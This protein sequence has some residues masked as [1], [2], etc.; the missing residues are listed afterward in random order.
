MTSDPATPGPEEILDWL[1]GRSDPERAQ[2]I[3]AA[4]AQPGSPARTFAEWAREFYRLSV[5]LPLIE[6]PPVVRQ[7]LRRMHAVR[8]GR[9]RPTK[10]LVARLDIDS[11]EP[12]ALVAVRGPLLDT[13]TRVQLAFTTDV[14]NVVLDI[15]PEA[16][17]RVTLRGQVLPRRAMPT[18]FHAAAHG[19]SGPVTSRDG[20]DLGSFTLANVG[21]DTELV[22]LTNDEVWIELPLVPT[23]PPT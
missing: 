12:D 23:P 10:R 22:V 11:R 13:P 14:A 17:G 3:E 18:A 6:P 21:V 20:D 15:A 5:Q 2:A 1:E 7:R 16:A 19:P 4:L 8:S 9:G